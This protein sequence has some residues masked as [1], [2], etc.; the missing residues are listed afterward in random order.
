VVPPPL[1][2]GP[3]KK[4]RVLKI[5]RSK[6]KP[7][8]RG[9]SEIEMA[10][11]KPVGVSKKFC[12]LDAAGSSHGPHVVGIAAIC[13]ARVLAFDNLIDDS[14]PDAHR[15]PSPVRTIERRGSPPLSMSGEFFVF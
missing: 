5:A 14:L 9:T 12:L 1:K 6:A 2:S 4:I 8:S 7:G 10:L 13:A 3:A 15:T 11:M